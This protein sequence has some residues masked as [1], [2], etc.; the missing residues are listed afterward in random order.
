M[1]DLIEDGQRLAVVAVTG[2]LLRDGFFRQG[3]PDQWYCC[4]SGIPADAQCVRMWVDECTNRLMLIYSHPSFAVIKPGN[5]VPY[6]CPE[7]T[8]T[9]VRVTAEE[10]AWLE[11]ARRLAADFSIRYSG[12]IMTGRPVIIDDGATFQME[13]PA[14][15]VVNAEDGTR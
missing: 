8:L 15:V 6:F 10:L 9:S 13:P 14:P 7:P 2:E 3:N 4:V 5:Q 12:A 11:Q 1:S